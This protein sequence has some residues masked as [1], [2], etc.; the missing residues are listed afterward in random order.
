MEAQPEP[1]AKPA[2]P[3]SPPVPRPPAPLLGWRGASDLLGPW[4]FYFLAKLLLLWR[5]LIGFHLLENLALAAALAVPLASPRWRRIRHWVAAPVAVALLYHDSWLP[6]A[7]RV[8]EKAALVSGFS[9]AYLAELAGRFVS[10][11]VVALLGV[12]AAIYFV[13]AR[14]VRMDAP[15]VAAM[16]TLPL[17]LAA[18][19]PPVGGG[20]SAAIA[21]APER[22]PPTPDAQLEAFYRKEA[23]RAVALPRPPEGSPPFDVVLLHVCSLSWDDLQA[24]GQDRHP[25]LASFDIVLRRFNSASTYSGPSVIRFLRATCGQTP[26]GALYAPAPDGCLL[27]S[28]LEGAGFETNLVLNHDGHFDDFLAYV[29]KQGV[30]AATMP[31]K[32]IPAPQ[33]SFDESQIHDDEAVLRRWLDIRGKSPAPRV[34]AIY[35]T[36]SLHDGNRLVADP[37]T[38]S[39]DTYKARQEKLLDDLAGFMKSLE[40]GKR[41]TVVILVPEHGAAV[42]GDAAQISGLREIPTP[43]ITLVPVGIRVLGP[44]ARRIGEALQVDEPTSYLAMSHI[45]SRMLAKPPFGEGGFRPADYAAGLPATDFVAESEAATVLR[46]GGTYLWRQGKEA[47]KELPAS[48]R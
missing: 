32:G 23:Q 15:V 40:G 39:R 18:P 42:R 47:W 21:A 43:A 37:K 2:S 12:A 10:V 26:Q 31:L 3:E 35:N 25:L 36:V 5:G 27:V 1:P 20:A 11:P 48:P 30:K 22:A 45:L 44:G 29:R 17:L 19:R 41:P 4:N 46:S 33:R 28:A 13:L 9:A 38:N 8:V 24:T 34:A 6:S 14:F 16:L 7:S